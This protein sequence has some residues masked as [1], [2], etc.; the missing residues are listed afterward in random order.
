MQVYCDFFSANLT[1]IEGDVRHI[2]EKTDT[3]W[4]LKRRSICL[5]NDPSKYSS[6][7]L[8]PSAHSSRELQQNGE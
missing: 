5:P 4:L 7:A 3:V 2:E 1:N 8:S 6:L